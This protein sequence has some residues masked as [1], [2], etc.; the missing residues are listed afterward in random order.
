M[1]HDDKSLLSLSPKFHLSPRENTSSF[2]FTD[3]F[4]SRNPFARQFFGISHAFPK[5]STVIQIRGK[6]QKMLFISWPIQGYNG[7][8]KDVGNTALRFGRNQ[9]ANTDAPACV[10]AKSLLSCLTLCNAMDCS[11][12][13]SPP[14]GFSRQ[15]YWRGLPRPPPGDLPGTEPVSPTFLHWQAVSLPLLPPGKPVDAPKHSLYPYIICSNIRT[16]SP[17]Q[18]SCIR[19]ESVVARELWLQR[20][21]NS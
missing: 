20:Q 19:R 7:P 5:T 1:V 17:Y 13:V 2:L 10:L 8:A 3:G 18:I 9:E 15:E 16:Q 11:P 4:Y 6:S 21:E 14:T 12:P